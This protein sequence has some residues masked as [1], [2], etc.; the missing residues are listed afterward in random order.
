MQV[1]REAARRRGFSAVPAI[2]QLAVDEERDA[3]NS[4]KLLG[5][6]T[7]GRT[8]SIGGTSGLVQ[9]S[10]GRFAEVKQHYPLVVH[11]Q[12]TIKNYQRRDALTFGRSLHRICEAVLRR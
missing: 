5:C 1:R 4:L 12:P 2:K 8:H 7:Q 10:K 11:F 9:V 3:R 6:T